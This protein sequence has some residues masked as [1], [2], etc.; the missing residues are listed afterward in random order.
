MDQK[1]VKNYFFNLIYNITNIVFPILMLS[2][3]SRVISPSGL[4]KVTYAQNICTYFMI[5]A[6][7]G[8]SKHGIREI[9]K[10]NGN[11]NERN[12]TFSEL[13][14]IQSVS[15]L[16]V[17]AIYYYCINAF[18]IFKDYRFLLNVIGISLLTSIINIEWFYTGLE[19]F[20]YIAK[21]N[22]VI[23]CL[24]IVFLFLFV[25]DSNDLVPYAV[26]L[27]FSNCGNHVANLIGLRKHMSKI[28]LPE[29]ILRHIKPAVLLLAMNIAVELYTQLDV[30]MIGLYYEDK[31]VAFYSNA[32]KIVRYITMLMTSVGSVIMPKM[33]RIAEHDQGQEFASVVNKAFGFICGMA[34]PASVGVA[35]LANDIVHVSL[36]NQYGASVRTLQILSILIPVL[37]IGNLMGAQS[38]IAL[39]RDNQLLI[40]VVL[41]A[42]INIVLNKIFI[43][44]YAHNGAA[45]AS[46]VAECVVLVAQYIMVKRNVDIEIDL[47]N[48]LKSLCG[49]ALIILILPVTWLPI[50]PPIRLI[51]CIA[52]GGVIYFAFSILTKNKY[53]I[54]MFHILIKLVRGN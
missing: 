33:S 43:P 4:G 31:Y 11:Q 42:F 14:I 54:Q 49:S 21:R 25:R 23:K 18:S 6:G 46:V 32:N 51:L 36:G 40:S 52:G 8:V 27:I 22:I 45:F 9:A 3:V 37:S 7:L 13:M 17:C 35:I 39:K 47:N 28:C 26:I 20:V 1:I 24:S 53:I 12:S 50:F 48:L 19:E 5:F 30:T 41:G 44:I 34:I 38:L 15:S 16:F 10:R 29:N 2:Y